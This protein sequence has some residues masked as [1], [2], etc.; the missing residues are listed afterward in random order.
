VTKRARLTSRSTRVA[1]A[2]VA[3]AVVLLTGC[4]SSPSPGGSATPAAGDP[5][6]QFTAVA[7]LS[8]EE[9]EAQLRTVSAEVERQLVTLSGL[10]K[11]LGGPEKATAAYTAMT[12][13]MVGVV[14]K[15]AATP[16]F[17]GKFGGLAPR[18]DTPSLGGMIFAGM[19]ASQLGTEGVVSATNDFKPDAKPVHDVKP[20]GDGSTITLDGSVG[21]AA[22]DFNLETTANGVTGKLRVKIEVK[23]CPDASGTFTAHIS[24]T[25]SAT[26][27][28]GRA[29]SN[30]TTDVTITGHV[31]DD[32]KLAG[33]DTAATTQAAE[34]GGGSN[35]WAEYTATTSWSG[36]NVTAATRTFGRT[37]GA[38]TPKFQQDW[39][40]TGTLTEYMV[41]KSALEAAQKAWESGRCVALVPTTSP[42]KR[43]GLDPSATVTITAPPRSKI[44]GGPVGGTVTATLSGQTSIDPA[45]SKVPADATFHYVAPGEKD[46]SASVALEARSKRGVAKASV[47]LDT[48]S[49]SYEVTGTMAS[50]PSGTTFTGTICG[51]EKPFTVQTTG[52][53]VGTASFV[54]KG[55]TA[56]TVT[57]K[58]KVG[59]APLAMVGNGSY[60]LTPPAGSGT[61]TLAI[62]WKLTIKIP[63]VG[64]QTR[65]GPATL[66]LTP[67]ARC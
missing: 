42:D 38:V 57:F 60:T 55:A 40:Q 3:S 24:I 2:T 10:E 18:A 21:S 6:A 52:D 1:A 37:S 12:A 15:R 50:A 28:A 11:E 34:F 65:S 54:P 22:M 17:V 61:G 32:A 16:G 31:D 30:T 20:D 62:T 64:D 25:A 39:A 8:P 35:K 29:G 9:R 53:M 14:Q 49:G 19:I 47:D 5:A 36:S 48:K 51:P 27:A 56:G 45:G 23:P 59:N 26:S 4:S 67:T 44:D 63:Y 13:A 58:G 7:A 66:T 43:S 33:Y 46:K 41:T